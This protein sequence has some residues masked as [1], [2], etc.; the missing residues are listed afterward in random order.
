MTL[1]GGWYEEKM[2]KG[3]CMGREGEGEVED[4][5]ERCGEVWWGE[6]ARGRG[7]VYLEEGVREFEVGGGKRVVVSDVGLFTIDIGGRCGEEGCLFMY[8]FRFF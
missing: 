4:V 1:D 2:R 5:L 6:E 7:V 8:A 3:A